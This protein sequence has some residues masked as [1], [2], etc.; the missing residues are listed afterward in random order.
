MVLG[1]TT[2]A[3]R[4]VQAREAKGLNRKRAADLLGVSLSTV[5]TWENGERFPHITLL[6]QIAK[7]LGVPAGFLVGD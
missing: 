1:D 7:M 3:E 6:P 5:Y 4:L 2:F